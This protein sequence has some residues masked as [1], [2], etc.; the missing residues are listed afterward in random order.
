M[1]STEASD[2]KRMYSDLSITTTPEPLSGLVITI[3]V[4]RFNCLIADK[5]F[6][7]GFG[8]LCRM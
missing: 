7:G 4:D 2:N 5:S 6:L 1:L 8:P 3:S